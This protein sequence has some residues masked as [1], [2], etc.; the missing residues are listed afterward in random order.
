MIAKSLIRLK[1]D[2]DNQDLLSEGRLLAEKAFEV[3]GDREA[4]KML[5]ARI[6]KS[7]LYPVRV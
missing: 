3:D 6:F 5:K 2:L 1:Q 7:T 4:G